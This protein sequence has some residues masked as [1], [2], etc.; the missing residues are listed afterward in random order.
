MSRGSGN[1]LNRER[2]ALFATAFTNG[3]ADLIDFLIPL[4]AGIALGAEASEVGF[5]VAAELIVSVLVR[6]VAGW[7]ADTR[8]RRS[9]AGVGAVTYGLSCFGYAIAD[10]MAIA[11]AAAVLGGVGGALLWVSLRAI[12]SERLDSDSGVFARMMSWQETG[13]WVAFV[14]GLLLLAQTDLFMPVFLACGVACVIGAIA[15][16]MSPPRAIVNAN[17]GREAIALSGARSRAVALRLRPMLITVVITALAESAVGILLLLHLQRGLGL[18]VIQIAYVFL[19]GAVAMGVLPPILHKVVLRIGRRLAMIAASVLS[20]VFA[21]SLAWAPN[22]VVIAGLW[23]LCGVAWAVLMPIEQSVITEAVREQVGRAMGIYTAAVLV[24]AAI[25]AFA[26]GLLYEFSSWQSACL[27][28]GAVILS[29]AI[30]GP[31]AIRRLGVQNTPTEQPTT[32]SNP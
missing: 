1:L 5:L 8:E 19:P 16:F 17:S 2:A 23:I 12:I 14:A 25:G 27:I 15:L 26:A 6:P 29:G 3:P 20:G 22:P 28:A 13:A 30:L 18:G 32:T 31:W 4:W 7:L 21:L 9:L 24:G 10:S 11:Y